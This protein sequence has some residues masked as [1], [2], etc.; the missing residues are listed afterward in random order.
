[1]KKMLLQLGSCIIVAMFLVSCLNEGVEFDQITSERIEKAGRAHNEALDA[2]LNELWVMKAEYHADNKQ[3][4]SDI[5]RNIGSQDIVERSYN[6]GL[7]AAENILPDMGIDRFKDDIS[8][9][10]I[11]KSTESIKRG[12]LKEVEHLGSFIMDYYG[13]LTALLNAKPKYTV[14][15]DKVQELENEIIRKAPSQE[16]GELMLTL[17]S[18]LR[19]SAEYWHKNT[20]KWQAALH[21]QVEDIAIPSEGKGFTR[22]GPNDGI[23]EQ[24][25]PGYYPYPEDRTKFIYVSEEGDIFLLKCPE[26]LVY[27]PTICACDIPENVENPDDDSQDRN[28]WQIAGADLAGGIS[29]SG[30][31]SKGGW[32]GTVAVAL[33]T[34]IGSSIM[35]G[36][37]Q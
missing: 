26:G 7:K 24:M 17:T 30:L 11:L 34:A 31:G 36:L 1:M 14:F 8:M 15:V 5:T 21:S 18:I 25:P 37:G 9:S 10:Q 33:G 35:E 6:I 13:K 16:E 12:D 20:S 19:H 22:S 23:L 3:F 27:N 29:G 4:P 32:V 2:V 28:W